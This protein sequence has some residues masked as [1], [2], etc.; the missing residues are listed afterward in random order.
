MKKQLVLDLPSSA[1]QEL[2][3]QKPN[4]TSFELKF[5]PDKSFEFSTPKT[6]VLDIEA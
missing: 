3:I 4:T 6:I 2:I 1:S 5:D